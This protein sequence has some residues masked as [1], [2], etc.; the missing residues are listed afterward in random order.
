MLIPL[1]VLFLPVNVFSSPFS[2]SNSPSIAT[3]T[4]NE[5]QAAVDDVQFDYSAVLN[6]TTR[7]GEIVFPIPSTTTIL[8]VTVG[9]P[10]FAAGIDKLLVEAQSDITIRS[11]TTI[12]QQRIADYWKGTRYSPPNQH[13]VIVWL[14]I[15]PLKGKN[16]TLGQA[17]DVLTGLR[18]FYE[19]KGQWKGHRISFRYVDLTGKTTQEGWGHIKGGS[20]SEHHE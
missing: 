3:P 1:L 15:R 4:L 5:R 7:N 16:L 13:Q 9:T 14:K 12:M 2:S 20:Y 10:F 17:K 8:F 11:R 19:Q 6:S 18:L